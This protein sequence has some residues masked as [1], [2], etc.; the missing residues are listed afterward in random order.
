MGWSTDVGDAGWIWSF[1]RGF[2]SERASLSAQPGVHI[3]DYEM[4]AKEQKIDVSIPDALNPM[5]FSEVI[6]ELM[7][8]KK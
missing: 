5:E 7:T 2:S 1:E 8:L 6:R 3:T 4:N